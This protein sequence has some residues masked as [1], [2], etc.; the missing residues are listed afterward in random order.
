MLTSKINF[1]KENFKELQ[2]SQ[3]GQTNT[4][5]KNESKDMPVDYVACPKP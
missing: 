3:R 5:Q 2:T 1:P 4:F